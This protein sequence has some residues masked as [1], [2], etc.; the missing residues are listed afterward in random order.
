M[1]QKCKILRMAAG[2]ERLENIE[3][4]PVFIALELELSYDIIQKLIHNG[5]NIR[6][7][8]PFSLEKYDTYPLTIALV[9]G[10]SMEYIKI[11]YNNSGI[12]PMYMRAILNY[13]RPSDDITEYLLQE[14]DE[15]LEQDTY[16]KQ[17]KEFR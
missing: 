17:W 12:P 14:M 15:Y 16:M 9:K 2:S 1:S 5:A 6:D 13:V 4:S 8:K 3:P 7:K 11:L 10:L